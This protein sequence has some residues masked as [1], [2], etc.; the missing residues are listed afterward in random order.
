MPVR[1]LKRG[2]GRRDVTERVRFQL[3]TRQG[4]ERGCEAKPTD[5]LR[6]RCTH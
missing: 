5:G 1:V 4:S 2:D 6:G 3:A